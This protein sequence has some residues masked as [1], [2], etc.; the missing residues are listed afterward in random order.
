MQANILFGLP[1]DAAN[2][3]TAVHA[4][5]LTEYVAAMHLGLDTPVAEKGTSLSGAYG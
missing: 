5:G 1:E 3:R 2:L 4:A